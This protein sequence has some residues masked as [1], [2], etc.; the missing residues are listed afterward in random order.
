MTVLEA[1]ALTV[2]YIQIHGAEGEPVFGSPQPLDS[3][4][5]LIEWIEGLRASDGSGCVSAVPTSKVGINVLQ[6]C[7]EAEETKNARPRARGGLCHGNA[8]NS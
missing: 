3:H 6:K 2:D 7:L 4:E 8:L 5:E 1:L